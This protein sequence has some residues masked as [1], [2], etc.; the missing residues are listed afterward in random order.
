MNEKII[1][2]AI[3]WIGDFED[4]EHGNVMW[5]IYTDKGNYELKTIGKHH[6]Y[7]LSDNGI[8]AEYKIH[9]N[10][11]LLEWLKSIFEDEKILRIEGL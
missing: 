8:V 7:V 3:A 11:E 2:D 9:S 4:I 6:F 5:A 10:D 1:K